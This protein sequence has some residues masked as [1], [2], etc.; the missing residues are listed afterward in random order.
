M[1]IP[2]LQKELD[3]FKDVVWN[4]QRIRAQKDVFLPNGVPN[5]MYDFPDEYNMTDCSKLL[6]GHSMPSV[7]SI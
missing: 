5:H 6:M 1:F 7:T 4:T 3:N 2:V